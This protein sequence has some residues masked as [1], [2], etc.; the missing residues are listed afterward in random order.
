MNM[1]LTKQEKNTLKG[2]KEAYFQALAYHQTIKQIDQESKQTILDAVVFKY[3]K[4]WKEEDKR[5]TDP[6]ADYLMS[7]KDFQDYME[8]VHD[9]RTKR[10]LKVPSVEYTSDFESWKLLRIAEDN[11]IDYALSVLPEPL[12]TQLKDIKK[13]FTVK[14]KFLD[15]VCRLDV[16]SV[17]VA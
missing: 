7:E 9:E 4:R 10:G 5:I 16:D 13:H 11:L 1:T 12:K 2:C 8:F 14:E 6:K 15:T 17:K 3:D